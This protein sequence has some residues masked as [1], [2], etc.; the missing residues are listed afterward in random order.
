MWS[1]CPRP[2]F[3]AQCPLL[4][5]WKKSVEA[6]VSILKVAFNRQAFHWF[7]SDKDSKDAHI[8]FPW[9]SST[10]AYEHSF[11]GQAGI[12]ITTMLCM[13]ECWKIKKNIFRM[14]SK[15]PTYTGGFDWRALR[16][17]GIWYW[18]YC[19]RAS[20]SGKKDSWTYLYCISFESRF[21]KELASPRTYMYYFEN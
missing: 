19:Y 10:P 16:R 2:F 3:L 12:G 7:R 11:K 5:I 15:I 9:G 6:E 20:L 8:P 4:F 14:E 1:P 17:E 18:V 21:E 13:M